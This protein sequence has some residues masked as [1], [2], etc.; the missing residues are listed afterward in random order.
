MLQVLQV[1]LARGAGQGQMAG[2][3]LTAYFGML[4]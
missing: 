3:T 4:Y 1:L 2:S